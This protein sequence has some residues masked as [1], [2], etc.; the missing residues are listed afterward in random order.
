MTAQAEDLGLQVGIGDDGP[1]D[2]VVTL[3]GIPPMYARGI[4]RWNGWIAEPRFDRATVDRIAAMLERDRADG[5]PSRI[6]WDGATAILHDDGA[7]Q[8]WPDQSPERIAPDPDGR[9]AIGAYSWCWYE[10]DETG[11]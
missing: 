1:F 3:A 11:V 2:A 6:E 4:P 10:W 5:S 8:D 9:Y 7:E